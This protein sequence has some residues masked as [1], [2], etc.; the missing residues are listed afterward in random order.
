MDRGGLITTRYH[1][2][3]GAQQID[4]LALASLVLP[5]GGLMRRAGTALFEEVVQRYPAAA[6]VLICCGSGNNAG[7]GYVLATLAQ[8]AGWQV[9]VLQADARELTGD[10]GQMQAEAR[11]AGVPIEG[12]TAQDAAQQAP[13]AIEPGTL[14]VDAV[15]GTGVTS[16]PRPTAAGLIERMN[17]TAAPRIAIDLPSGL[18]PAATGGFEAAPVLR[19]DLT[20][21]FIARKLVAYSGA[22]V[23]CTGE[24]VEKD[25]GVPQ[26]LLAQLDA[27]TRPVLGLR[28]DPQSLPQRSRAGYQHRHG[29]VLVVGGDYGMPGAALLSAEAAL[30][31]GAGLVSVVTRGAHAAAIVAR[32]PELMVI[33]ADRG[34]QVDA[35]LAAADLIILGPGLGRGGWG[36]D[37]FARTVA[38]QRPTVIDA[39]GLWWLADGVAPAPDDCIVTPHTAEAALR[40]GWQAAAVE[41]DR[42]A[43]VRALHERDGSVALLKGPGTLIAGPAAQPVRLCE[44]GNSSMGTAGMGDVLAG[45][46]GGLRAQGLSSLDAACVGA[47]L[48]GATADR[49]VAERGPRGLLAGDVIDNLARVMNG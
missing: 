34:Q 42:L 8:A 14:L 11:A 28:F 26:S 46:I 33:D 43:C 29:R 24:L 48:H 9:R 37:L 25:L 15:L 47:S 12:F 21:S 35:G 45:I 4:T 16:P 13:L 49:L 1:T 3:A 5:P 44:H 18:N 22:G 40:L 27:Q 38:A 32:R 17:L 20:V 7:D 41:R 36:R 2:A 39:D 6:R 23:A 30:R 10:A 19:A 31:V